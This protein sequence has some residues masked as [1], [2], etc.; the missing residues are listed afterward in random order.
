MNVIYG[1]VCLDLRVLPEQ[2]S[3]NQ[4]PVGG[5]WVDRGQMK[6]QELEE[7][8]SLQSGWVCV[9][10]ASESTEG[11]AARSENMVFAVKILGVEPVLVMTRFRMYSW[12]CGGIS[13]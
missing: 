7:S 11:E 10:E 13:V 9:S 4:Q 2:G 3:D 1:G 5:R 6:T 12:Q 8:T